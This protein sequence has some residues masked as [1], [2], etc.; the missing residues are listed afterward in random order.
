M[1]LVTPRQTLGAA[2]TLNG[3]KRKVKGIE[4]MGEEKIQ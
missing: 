1:I 2:D 3:M 4:V